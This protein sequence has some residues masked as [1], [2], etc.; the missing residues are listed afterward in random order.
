MSMLTNTELKTVCTPVEPGEDIRHILTKMRLGMKEGVGGVGLAANQVGE[1][2]RII[3]IA[4]GGFIETMINPVI[5]R[6]Y[7]GTINSREGCLSY[8]GRITLLVRHKKVEVTCFGEDWKPLR[9]KLS[10]L[11]AIIVQHELDHLNGRSCVDM[12]KVLR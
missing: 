9:F 2:K 12:G 3:L 5:V 10:G 8:P 4:N 11:D 7:G 6:K 1:P